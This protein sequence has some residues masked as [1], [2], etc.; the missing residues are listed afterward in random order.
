[1]MSIKPLVDKLGVKRSTK[2]KP[3][4][5]EKIFTRLLDHAMA[6]V[7]D[8]TGS[9]GHNYWRDRWEEIDRKYL[10]PLLLREL[11]E[12]KD[13]QILQVYTNL[14]IK[15][16]LEYVKS[17]GTF[18]L[19]HASPSIASFLRRNASS[20]VL[21]NSSDGIDVC[22]DMQSVGGTGELAS[23][24]I[25]DAQLHHLQDVVFNS[26]HKTRKQ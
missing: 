11:P 1:G 10:Q 24:H 19:Q 17:A 21:G 5:G 14:N 23:R 18:N 16:A 12:A 8:I 22:I 26:M 7:E 4:M 13:T 2:H 15:D 6:G 25:D 9:H 20:N 3:S